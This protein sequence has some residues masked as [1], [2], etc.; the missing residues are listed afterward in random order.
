MRLHANAVPEDRSTAERTRRIDGDDADCLAL[1]AVLPRY[2]V[3]Q[4]ALS[5]ARR[6]CQPDERRI[7]AVWK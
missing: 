4:R 1:F 3:N 7:A 6:S 2:L 5:G